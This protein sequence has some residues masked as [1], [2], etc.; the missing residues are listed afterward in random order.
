MDR[1]PLS[2]LRT[3]AIGSAIRAEATK[4]QSELLRLFARLGVDDN[5]LAYR[6]P[7]IVAGVG[8]LFSGWVRFG[9]G[10]VLRVHSSSLGMWARG[11]GCGRHPPASL[12]TYSTGSGTSSPSM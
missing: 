2:Y 8:A 9:C 10:R 11:R 5:R 1:H 4:V 12:I 3:G 6:H 7:A